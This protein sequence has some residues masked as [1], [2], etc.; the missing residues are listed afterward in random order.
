MQSIVP[1]YQSQPESPCGKLAGKSRVVFAAE[2]LCASALKT[3]CVKLCLFALSPLLN[4]PFLAVTAGETE[5]A[6]EV[7]GFPSPVGLS[8][9]G[10]A[11]A[12]T[13]V[14]LFAANP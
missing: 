13:A 12:P 3:K 9:L 5:R 6:F 8:D 1:T 14:L 10:E 2:S 4:C 7:S 11:A